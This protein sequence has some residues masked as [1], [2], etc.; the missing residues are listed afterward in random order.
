MK[1]NQNQIDLI[2]RLGDYYYTNANDVGNVVR[3]AFSELWELPNGVWY[4]NVHHPECV[5]YKTGDRSGYGFDGDGQWNESTSWAFKDCG[6]NWKEADMSTIFDA[7]KAEAKRRELVESVVIKTDM[8]F[9]IA[10]VI[11]KGSTFSL[12]ETPCKLFL[13]SACIFMNGEW[14]KPIDNDIQQSIQELKDKHKDYNITI[15]VERKEGV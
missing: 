10:N 1:I 11:L 8:E 9:E 12:T 13:G 7:L 4:Q 15:V 5:V 3:D 6:V 2:K 14:A